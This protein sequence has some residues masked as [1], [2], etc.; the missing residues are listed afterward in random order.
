M[1]KEDRL[2]KSNSALIKA[3][4]RL[5]KQCGYKKSW[6]AFEFERQSYKPTLEDFQL[7]GTQ[8][9]YKDAWADI[10]FKEYYN[11]LV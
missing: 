9:G 1:K 10:K 8:M 5:A 6:V 2:Y 11:T 3:L 4:L 7:L